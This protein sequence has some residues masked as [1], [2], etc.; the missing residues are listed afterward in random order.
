MQVTGKDNLTEAGLRIKNFSYAKK[1]NPH[2]CG[3]PFLD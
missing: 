1:R 3:L 2:F